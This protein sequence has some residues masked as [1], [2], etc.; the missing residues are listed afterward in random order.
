MEIA[1][2]SRR[3]LPTRRSSRSPT[4][5]ADP[6][7]RGNCACRSP[8]RFRL[9]GVTLGLMAQSCM[10][11]NRLEWR[12]I[13]RQFPRAG[14]AAVVVLGVCFAF[15][16]A[17]G[18]LG[19]Q[20]LRPLLPL[21]FVLMAA[22]PWLFLDR[23]GRRQIGIV[24][25]NSRLTY[26]WATVTGALL[27]VACGVIG[28]RL[29]GATQD[30]WFVSIALNFQRSFDTTGNST[31]LLFVLFTTPALIFSPL[32][33]EIFFRGMLQRS[34]EEAL[35]KDIS[36]YLECGAFAVVHLCHHGLRWSGNKPSLLLPSALLWMALMFFAARLFAHWR[37]IAASIFPAVV[38]HIAFN[39]TMCIYI[40][41]FVWG[42]LDEA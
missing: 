26:A 41:I 38:S 30:N 39:A 13:F 10:H 16:R 23:G 8:S 27:A 35:P 36:T 7:A 24:Y 19:P 6:G 25:A 42:R 29:F 3:E 32:G 17:F 4:L 37:T 9:L 11:A 18:V 21:S 1:L 12:G 14:I 2:R 33:E 15:M 22:T 20:Y 5:W 31:L 40:F 34:L 28:S